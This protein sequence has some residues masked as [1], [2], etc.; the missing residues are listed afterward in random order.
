L[1]NGANVHAVRADVALHNRRPRGRVA[2]ARLTNRPSLRNVELN[3]AAFTGRLDLAIIRH[4]PSIPEPLKMP[5]ATFEARW[6][7]HCRRCLHGLSALACVV[8]AI[9]F[10]QDKGP[11]RSIDI[12]Q[13][14]DG[15]VANVVMFAPVAPNIAWNV[16]TDFDN[17]HKWV[18]NVRGSKIAARD[19]NVVTVEQ[20]GVAKFGLLSFP[21]TSVRRMQLD[22][23]NTI[24]STQV[25]GSMRRLVSLMKVSPDG[26]GTRL[27][28]KL[29][30]EPA[31]IA[32]TVMSKDFL[33][34]EITEQ[35][36]AIV[37]EMGKRDK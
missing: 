24:Q 17:M 7:V 9:A 35:F 29:E 36:T 3:R 12:V 20:K 25:S 18:P 32:A 16:L 31:G 4:P 28:Y 26:G 33:Q 21:Y 13:N 10:A 8:A 22:P 37:G 27:D 30:I 14:N 6:R 2:T 11:V 34:H 1:R 5:I 19:G 23:Q 15:Y